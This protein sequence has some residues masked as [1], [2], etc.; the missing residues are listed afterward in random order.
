MSNNKVLK[1][2][3][4]HLAV[5]AACLAL[6]S[7][8]ALATASCGTDIS[9]TTTT[10]CY[11]SAGNDLTVRNGAGV[12]MTSTDAITIDSG[13]TVG[14]ITNSGIIESTYG[15]GNGIQFY[16]HGKAGAI[17]NNAGGI[18]RGNTG[19]ALWTS[20]EVSSITNH[21]TISGLFGDGIAVYT[22]G[23][24]VN[25]I[26]NTG[27]ISG[28]DNGIRFASPAWGGEADVITNLTNSS[29]GTIAGGERGIVVESGYLLGSIV[30]SGTITGA[31]AGIQVDREGHV[32]GGITN[33]AGG[34]I[35][36]GTGN[37]IDVVRDGS[38]TRITNSGT[39]T[40]VTGIHTGQFGDDG[41]GGYYGGSITDGIV[42]TASGSIIGTGGTAIDLSGATG[43]VT[44]TNSGTI[45]GGVNLGETT[46]HVLNLDGATGSISGAVTGRNA[47]VNVNGS[48]ST[49]NTFDVGAF[50]IASGGVLNMGDG[51]GRGITVPTLRNNGKLSVAA[52][53]TAVIS[54]NYVQGATGVFETGAS[55]ASHYG[56]LTVSG[57]ADLSASNKLAVNVSANDTLANG[58]VLT[59]V[60]H[61]TGT[62]TAGP[63]TVADNSALWDFSAAVNASGKGIDITTKRGLS[64]RDAANPAA[65]GAA[66]VLDGMMASG[67]GGTDMQG[68]I[69]ALGSLGTAAQ[70]G[71]AVNQLLPMQGTAQAAMNAGYGASHVVQSRLDGGSAGGNPNGGL[72]SGDE[73]KGDR[74]AWAKPFG[75]WARQSDSDGVAGYR[76]DMYGLVLGADSAIGGA[77]RA[78]AAFA[79]SHSKVDGNASASSQHAKVDSYQAIVYGSHSLDARTALD[80]QLDVGNHQNSANRVI[81]FGGLN[82]AASADYDSWSTHVGVGVRRVMDI[83]ASTSFEPTLRADYMRVR[84]SSYTESGAGDLSLKV[85]S[86]TTDELILLAGG[87]LT[88]ALNRGTRL[89]ANL[90]VGYDALG[91]SGTITSSFVGGGAAFATPSIDPSRWL[92][93][94]GFGVVVNQTGNVEVTA[95]Y[96]FEARRGFTN[97]TASVKLRMPF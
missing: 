5:A 51:A 26:T 80:F 40:G 33:N 41:Y 71:A 64:V 36:G 34:V 58:A 60:L 50:N 38:V 65:Q 15:Y 48:F 22:G 68:V 44:I 54:G 95:G 35:S 62:L 46:A 87:K 47:T 4:M 78:G 75:S 84:D 21:G 74:Q 32:T 39:I 23:G 82:R 1:H 89:T 9:T 53:N 27:T 57:T 77:T 25:G 86:R 31:D 94:G 13:V 63:L 18:I 16:D 52:G 19:L 14:N 66:G 37:G 43:A 30:N 56:K 79:F 59:D 69:N 83:N 55:S 96:D 11:I 7:S 28:S 61:A 76:A 24:A 20:N 42:N 92:T 97:Q 88:H 70:V 81:N 93:R 3:A 90:G 12:T 73:T 67:A 29:T 8:A 49:A 6:A 85:N 2:K 17:L 10:S 72:S 45:T 91:G